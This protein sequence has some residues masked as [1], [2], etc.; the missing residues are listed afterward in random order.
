MR[1]RNRGRSRRRPGLDGTATRVAEASYVDANLVYTGAGTILYARW[2]KHGFGQLLPGATSPSRETDLKSLGVGG[3]GAGGLGLVPS[4]FANAGELRALAWPEGFFYHLEVS[5]S[6][7]LVDVKGSNQ[8]AELPNGPGG[9]AYVPAGSPGFPNQSLIVAEWGAQDRVA[10]YEVDP[11]GDPMTATRREF[12]MLF[13][14]PWG[15]Y[16]EPVSG[17][18]SRRSE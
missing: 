15:A 5:T 14:R 4:G 18:I 16:F 6:G 17:A 2:P 11:Q 1:S 12:F 7:A 13:P 9:F 3:A 8:R 10:V